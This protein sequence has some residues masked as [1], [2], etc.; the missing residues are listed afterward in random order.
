MS[1]APTKAAAA[2]VAKKT[3][4]RKTAVAKKG[5]TKA[6]RAATTGVKDVLVPA[7]DAEKL[8]KRV[9][10]QTVENEST[11]K[12]DSGTK[13]SNT[14]RRGKVSNALQKAQT[15]STTTKRVR[16]SAK[17]ASTKTVQAEAN[18]TKKAS[19]KKATS[20]K[21]VTRKEVKDEDK[22]GGKEVI[23]TQPVEIDQNDI[24]RRLRPR[25]RT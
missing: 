10:S 12:K 13:G 4:V 5:T 3:T 23:E 9:Q 15:T 16:N 11:V 1:N 6:A 17:N 24:R 21:K 7:K 19:T 8:K 18:A 14:R 20:R 25:K 2:K 22:E